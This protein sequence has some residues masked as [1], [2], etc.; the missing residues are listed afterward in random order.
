M[1]AQGPALS[2]FCASPGPFL[3]FSATDDRHQEWASCIPWVRGE[4]GV[5]GGFLGSD[6]GE[7][8]DAQNGDLGDR[9]REHPRAHAPNS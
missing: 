3:A 8:G 1:T 9:L 4:T 5:G 6:E 2:P 7:T